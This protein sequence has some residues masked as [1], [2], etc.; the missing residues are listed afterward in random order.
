MKAIH[1]R[2]ANGERR[3]DIGPDYPVGRTTIKIIALE[4]T[5]D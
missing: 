5:W 3:A 1:A 2:A 4:N